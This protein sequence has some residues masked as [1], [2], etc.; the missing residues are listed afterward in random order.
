MAKGFVNT[1]SQTKTAH[2]IITDT[3][4]AA[5][6][7]NYC[8]AV[9]MNMSAVVTKM[10]R[11]YLDNNVSRYELMSREELIVELKKMEAKYE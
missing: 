1:T 11:E 5:D 8:R 3:Q 4:T 6:L 9:N 7:R 10:V 2:V